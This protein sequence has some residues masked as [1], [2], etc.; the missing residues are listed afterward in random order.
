MLCLKYRQMCS[1]RFIVLPEKGDD[2]YM[3]FLDDIIRF[4]LKDIFFIFDFDDIFGIYNKADQ[5]CR[6]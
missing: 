2:K 4:G 5:R 3:I 1:P 6:T